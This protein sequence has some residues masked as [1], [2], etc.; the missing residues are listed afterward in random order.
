[1][2]TDE[3]ETKQ[4][5]TQMNFDI[6]DD[7]VYITLEEVQGKTE[8]SGPI[9][10]VESFSFFGELTIGWTEKLVIPE[11]PNKIESSKVVIERIFDEKQTQAF[12][13]FRILQTDN[14]ELWYDILETIQ[15]DVES[16]ETLEKSEVK[17]TIKK[18]DIE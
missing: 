10:Y 9:P 17:W 12:S 18:Y 16:S 1:M 3:G 7:F 13:G 5:A 2:V 11:E 8:K 15:I 14:F 6:T 4:I